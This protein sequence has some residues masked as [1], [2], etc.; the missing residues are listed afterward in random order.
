ML[1]IA[2]LVGIIVV[3]SLSGGGGAS[4]EA[5]INQVTGSTNGVPVDDRTGTPAAP[6]SRPP[7]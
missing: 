4:G 6:A 2:V 5:H 7:T 3:A 1:A